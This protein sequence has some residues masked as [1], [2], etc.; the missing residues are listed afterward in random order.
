MDEAI[1]R[2]K[3]AANAGADVCFIEGVR[4]K[5]LLE[6]TVK[7]LAPKPV[8]QFPGYLELL[9]YYHLGV[10]ERHIRRTHA[11]VHV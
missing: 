3:L 10:G 6:K 8:S 4:S 9:P 2:L 7:A 1:F 11:F 5:E